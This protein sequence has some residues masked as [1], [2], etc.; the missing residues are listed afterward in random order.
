MKDNVI[1]FNEDVDQLESALEERI[2]HMIYRKANGAL[3]DAYGTRCLDLIPCHYWPHG[4]RTPS[5]KV[6]TYWD[7]Q[8]GGWRS[9]AR[10]RF[11]GF[12]E[13]EHE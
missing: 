12:E 5:P 13:E 3:R 4:K 10:S 1:I 9:L 6:L 2:V 8:R 11:V 7:A